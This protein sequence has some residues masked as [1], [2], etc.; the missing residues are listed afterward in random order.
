MFIM[1]RQYNTIVQLL[2]PTYR[3]WQQVKYHNSWSDEILQNMTT[4]K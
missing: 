2:W 4:H 3:S 1:I